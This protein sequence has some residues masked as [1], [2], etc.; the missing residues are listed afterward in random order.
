MAFALMATLPPIYGLYTATLPS[1]LYALFG[2]SKHLSVGPAGLVA[3]FFPRACTALLGVAGEGSGTEAML[4]RAALA[5]VLSFWVGIVF[6]LCG[7]LRIS[8]VRGGE[9]QRRCTG[10]FIHLMPLSVLWFP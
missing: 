9:R 4:K 8:K 2:T 7:M 1:I 3:V 6:L 10:P 5:P